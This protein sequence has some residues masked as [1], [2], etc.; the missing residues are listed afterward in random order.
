MELQMDSALVK[1]AFCQGLDKETQKHCALRQAGTVEEYLEAA[2][3]YE[4]INQIG[5]EK[6]EI[7]SKSQ[8]VMLTG[9]NQD[10]FFEESREAYN[11]NCSWNGQQRQRT[12]FNNDFINNNHDNRTNFNGKDNQNSNFNYSNN[13]NRNYNSNRNSK[14]VV[15]QGNQTRKYRVGH[16]P[17]IIA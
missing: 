10:R 11:V 7:P 8:Q 6:E 5:E 2:M 12:N 3:E 16:V 15:L 4:K 17:N 9:N 13:S 1:Q 14:P